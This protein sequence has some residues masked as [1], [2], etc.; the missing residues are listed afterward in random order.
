MQEDYED[1][2]NQDGEEGEDAHREE[3][4][5]ADGEE[6]ETA[7]NSMAPHNSHKL[8]DDQEQELAEWFREHPLFW[9]HSNEDFKNRQKKNRL[10]QQKAREMNLLHGKFNTYI[11]AHNN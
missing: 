4:E 7:P 1:G 10:L 11:H 5:N 6:G 8:D 3:G 2:R 9:N